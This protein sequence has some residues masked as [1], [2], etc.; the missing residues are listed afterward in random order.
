MK[1][2]NAVLQ[3]GRT[4]LTDVQTLHILEAAAVLR[5]QLHAIRTGEILTSQAHLYSW[6]VDVE[7]CDAG[8]AH[9]VDFVVHRQLI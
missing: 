2:H 1:N 3:D 6:T 9:G 8:L 5:A 4:Q 7:P